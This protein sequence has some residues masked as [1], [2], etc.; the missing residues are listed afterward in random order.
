MLSL[1]LYVFS[2]IEV[3]KEGS[4]LLAILDILLCA[5]LSFL[6]GLY[7]S[8]VWVLALCA[9]ICAFMAVSPIYHRWRD[10]KV[11]KMKRENPNWNGHFHFRDRWI[12][13]VDN[14]IDLIANFGWLYIVAILFGKF[15]A[16]VF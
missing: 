7:F 15:L 12:Y 11:R 9:L 6:A 2:P 10:K 5:I 16:W 13:P 4:L 8:F 14:F 3:G 1:I